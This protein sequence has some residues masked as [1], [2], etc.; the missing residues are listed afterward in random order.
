MRIN[1][2]RL[3]TFRSCRRKYYWSYVHEGGGIQP[4]YTAMPLVNG[5]AIHDGLA[6]HYSGQ[7]DAESC[8]AMAQS[9]K[10]SLGSD[11]SFDEHNVAAE[12]IEWGTRLLTAYFN[13]DVVRY[14]SLKD[15]FQVL[16]V[17]SEFEVALALDITY[18]GRADLI[19]NRDNRI[20]VP[21]HK[22]AKSV[23]ESTLEA[24]RQ[25][26][27]MLGYVWGVSKATGFD[28]RQ[29]GVNILK[30][31]K[32]VGQPGFDTK[33]C[34]TCKNTKSKKPDCV[35]C[36]GKGKVPK[37]P[38]QMFYRQW[39]G[40]VPEDMERFKL[41][42]KVSCYDILE[43]TNIFRCANKG[44]AWPMSSNCHTYGSCPYLD[45]CW[46]NVDPV[47]WYKTPDYA[48][49]DF[50]QRPGDYV[51]LIEEETRK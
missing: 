34:P 19:V 24:Y 46:G 10:K 16:Q 3:A 6:A 44:Y 1:N 5:T 45:L 26:F 4:K 27:Q 12:S 2:S 29:Y 7:T 39:F 14:P 30:K 11:L 20:A 48:L 28:V 17:E 31:L 25:S 8:E 13:R 23:S 38:P 18:V 43:D 40:V 51:D 50:S 47:A 9:Y 42:A 37:E 36:L 22:T 49:D 33:N 21:D 41:Q 32:T 35:T 15:D